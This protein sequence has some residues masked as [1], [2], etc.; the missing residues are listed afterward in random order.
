MAYQY[1][2]QSG[3]HQFLA[4]KFN[5]QPLFHRLQRAFRAFN[6]DASTGLCASDEKL[7]TIDWGVCDNVRKSGLLFAPSLLRWRAAG[8]LAEMAD[9]LADGSAGEYRLEQE[10]IRASLMNYFYDGSG[11]FLS[12]TG[13]GRQHDLIAT[14]LSVSHGLAADEELSRTLHALKGCWHDRRGVDDDGYVRCFPE[15]EDFSTTSAWQDAGH[16]TGEYQ[17]GGYWAYAAGFFIHALSLIDETPA[18][19]YASRFIRHTLTH[20]GA[21]Y[22]WKN[23]KL[24]GCHSGLWYGPSITLPYA[25]TRKLENFISQPVFLKPS[26]VAL[27]T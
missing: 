22:E 2:I 19:D 16:A 20:D 8:Q 11:L 4:Q 21:P 3:E 9:L 7:H 5:G 13:V 27:Q 24:G 17:N 15:D 1:V 12:A 25:A 10:K 23:E 14:L 6:I 18:V 26:G